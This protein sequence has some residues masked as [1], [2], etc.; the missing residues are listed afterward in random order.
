MYYRLTMNTCTGITKKGV[1]CTRKTT[2]STCYQHTECCICFETKSMKKT[3][4]CTHSFCKTCLDKLDKCALCRTQ[5]RQLSKIPT[6]Q[7]VL[8]TAILRVGTELIRDHNLGTMLDVQ[9]IRFE[10]NSVFVYVNSDNG[11][12]SVQIIFN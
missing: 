12:M 4:V 2:A 3:N 5:I 8:T 1:A 11:S 6:D 7:Y 10:G 9:I